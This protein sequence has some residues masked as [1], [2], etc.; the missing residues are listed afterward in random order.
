M[1][2]LD[3]F[4]KLWGRVGYKTIEIGLLKNVG[5]GL[6]QNRIIVGGKGGVNQQQRYS[7]YK[8]PDL[9]RHMLSS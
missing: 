9:Q 6:G 5:R 4:L 7:G 1:E 3:L 2:L 8:K